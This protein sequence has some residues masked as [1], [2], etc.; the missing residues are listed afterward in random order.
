MKYWYEEYRIMDSELLNEGL[1]NESQLPQNLQ[2][3][4]RVGVTKIV[5]T[6]PESWKLYFISS[7]KGDR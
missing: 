4:F 7:L 6:Y 3:Y 1:L 2:P 5:I